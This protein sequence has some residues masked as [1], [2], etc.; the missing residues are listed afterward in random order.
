MGMCTIYASAVQRMLPGA[1][2]AVDPFHV[3]QLAVKIVGD[4]RRRAVRG[5]Y[6]RRGRS[7]NP[8]YGVKNLLA[9]NLEHLTPAQF[10]KIIDTLGRDALGH[11][12]AIAWI[13][14]EKLR[15]VLNLRAR[16]TRTTPCERQV[17]DRLFTFYDWC[18]RNDA[19]PEL[20]SLAKTISCWEDEI[21]TAVLTGVT[22]ATSESLRRLAKLEASLAYGF[23]NPANQ[24]RR[25][26]IACTRGQWFCSSAAGSGICPQFREGHLTRWVAVRRGFGV[27]PAGL[28]CGVK[29]LLVVQRLSRAAVLPG[30]R[31]VIVATR[32]VLVMPGCRLPPI[33]RHGHPEITFGKRTAARSRLT[34]KSR[35]SG[36]FGTPALPESAMS[37][38]SRQGYAGDPG[39]PNAERTPR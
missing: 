15:D 9:R 20:A 25:V 12:I 2:L 5:K 37:V 38:R 23:R 29:G 11:E 39:I 8:E 14:K 36:S 4:V 1:V 7:G 24:R 18:A 34:S 22:N 16:I 10:A 21:V 17:R 33:T 26:R 35:I 32:R 13:A 31:G 27:L 6:G 19:V 28:P 3:V 30:V